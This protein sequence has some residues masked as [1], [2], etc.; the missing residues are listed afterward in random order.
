VILNDD[1]SPE[2][3]QAVLMDMFAPEP[4]NEEL[5]PFLAQ[6]RLGQGIYHPLIHDPFYQEAMNKRIN[7]MFKHK[8]EAVAKAIEEGRWASMLFLHERP[9][10]LEALEEILYTHEIDDPEIVWPLIASVW[11]DSENINQNLDQ[12]LE[13][14]DS[15]IPRRF[16]LVMD[17]EE[18]AAL[19]ALP[20]TFEIYRGMGAEE[21][22][23]GMSWTTDKV[24]ATWFA[25]RFSGLTEHMP[26]LATATVAKANVLAHFLGRNE[27]EIVVLP[28]NVEGMV[29]KRLRK[30]VR[31]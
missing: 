7:A 21:A 17:E 18:R 27:S 10:R 12:W 22:A 19:A 23:D 9:Y 5:V 2:E 29:V 31:K 26:Y 1:A 25:H 4:L 24:K 20:E 11:T 30:K 28:E 8:T 14:W 6:G 3:K 15:S 13:V 16:E